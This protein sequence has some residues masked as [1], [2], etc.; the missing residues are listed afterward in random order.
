MTSQTEWAVL[1]TGSLE[2]LIYLAGS[3]AIQERL[4]GLAGPY[5]LWETAHL[6]FNSVYLWTGSLV[7]D[8]EWQITR[9]NG[10]FERLGPVLSTQLL[11]AIR[12]PAN[13][14]PGSSDGEV[15]QKCARRACNRTAV[16][17]EHVDLPGNRYC[18]RCARNINEGAGYT[19]VPLPKRRRLTKH[20]GPAIGPGD[21]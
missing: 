5:E 4:D 6:P 18:A 10:S 16:S 13:Q 14:Q 8:P 12:A 9:P 19:L 17:L 20:R 3:P 7:L 11:D 1:A 2:S 15:S 21:G